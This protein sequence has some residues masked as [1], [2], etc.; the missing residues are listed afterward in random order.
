MARKTNSKP[1]M[2][3]G[4]AVL[5]ADAFSV[6]SPLNLWQQG[7]LVALKRWHRKDPAAFCL[8]E[9][10]SMAPMLLVVGAR[11]WGM[12][13]RRTAKRARRKGEYRPW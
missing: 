2:L 3:D 13:F 6:R 10:P 12:R 4:R 1:L 9:L 8:A 11:K 5:R 7:H